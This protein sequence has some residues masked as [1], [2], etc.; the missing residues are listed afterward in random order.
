MDL[1]S[2]GEDFGLITARGPV[3]RNWALNAVLI[4]VPLAGSIAAWFGGPTLHPT[5]ITLA[6]FFV[7]FVSETVGLGLGNHRLFSHRSF[8][9]GR[10]GRAVLAVFGSWGLQ[11]P[12][13]RWVADHRR[14]HRFT[15][16]PGDPHSPY[17]VYRKPVSS[18]AGGLWHAHFAWM[19][20]DLVT[21]KERYA[22]DIRRDPIT[23]WCSDHY[24]L[25]CVS[26]LLGPALVGYALGGDTE[27]LRSL[28][29]AGC[30][31]ITL[32]QHLVFSVNSIGHAIGTKV[33]GSQDE[34]RDNVVLA[35]LLFGDGLHSYHHRRPS[36]AVNRPEYLDL[37]GAILRLLERMHLVWNLKRY[38]AER[39]SVSQP[40][41]TAALN[42]K[43]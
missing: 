4:F 40:R 24:A 15:D 6:L 32:L 19:F 34:S 38:P 17:W 31:R 43:V 5:R 25:L 33:D 39:E 41:M 14:H 28:L 27:A 12:I 10:I 3:V 9:I 21:D 23:R 1:A 18:R 8:E 2:A 13:D 35:L 11:G 26:S 37:N 42:R 20:T 36:A 16:R 29:W 22:A 7:F 30:F